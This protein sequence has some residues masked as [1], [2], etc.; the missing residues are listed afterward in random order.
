MNELRSYVMDV[1]LTNK[2]F[3]ILF[4]DL[5]NFKLINEQL[6]HDNGDL[7][8][9]K[10]AEN[11]RESIREIDLVARMG[12]DE[13]IVLLR[14]IKDEQDTINIV[15]NIIEKFQKPIVVNGKDHVLTCSIGVASY[16][17]H[18]TTPEELIKNADSALTQVKQKSKNNYAVY[19]KKLENMS[20]ERRII[21]NAMRKG[22]NEHQ[23]FL[24]YQPK[25]NIHNDEIV[26]MEALVRWNHPDLGTIPPGKFI[27]LAEETGL[28]IP[29]GEWI[30]NESCKQAKEWRE[31]GFGQLIVSVNV[32]VRQLQDPKFVQQVERVLKET[33][34]NPKFLELEVTESIFADLN[35][36]TPILKRL[37]S[38]GIH[39]SVDDFGTGY[40]SLSYIKHLPIDT[41]K[42]D[43]SFV[44]D[45]HKNE[46]SKAIVRAIINLAETIGLKVIA[47]GIEIEEQVRALRND[48]CIFGQGYFYSRPLRKEAFEE[49]I[50]SKGFI[51]S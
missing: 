32:S 17:E 8:I 33:G 30:L 25:F 35:C 47:E 20:L 50:R 48:G 38:L 6:G 5:D 2:K 11:I 43:A 7:V 29:L 21:E 41:L 34:F 40:S 24:E 27:S 10:A 12:G 14:D 19:N 37:R 44:K 36:I 23:F 45:I 22:L 1:R 31:K 16:P 9:V 49:Y 18:G 39:I 3:S 46:E 4:I 26:G 42:V 28:I 51:T 13:F 15:N